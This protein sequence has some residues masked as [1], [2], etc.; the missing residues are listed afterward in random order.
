MFLTL[1]TLAG[2]GVGI[3]ARVASAICALS[4]RLKAGAAAKAPVIIAKAKL[5]RRNIFFILI[6]IEWVEKGWDKG[7]GA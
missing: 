4:A 2:K 7:G 6:K 1:G 3:K 5:R